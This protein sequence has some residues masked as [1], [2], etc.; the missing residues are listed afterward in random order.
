[1]DKIQLA[2]AGNKNR[3]T[4]WACI[5]IRLAVFIILSDTKE[6]QKGVLAFAKITSRTMDGEQTIIFGKIEQES[7]TP[8]NKDLSHRNVSIP[9]S[10]VKW[11][12]PKAS[13]G[14]SAF[15]PPSSNNNATRFSIKEALPALAATCN[16]VSLLFT[17]GD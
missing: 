1:M 3:D 16:A 17:S 12:D 4:R 10:D 7:R 13:L 2:G 5:W 6:I 9:G 14:A 11:V 8:E 15:T